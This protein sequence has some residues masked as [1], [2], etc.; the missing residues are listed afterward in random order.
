MYR[1]IPIPGGDF[2]LNLLKSGLIYNQYEDS[3]LGYGEEY[4]YAV[5]Y[6]LGDEEYFST[7]SLNFINNINSES[8]RLVTATTDEIVYGCT[9]P[10]ACS[11]NPDANYLS[12]SCWWSTF[13]CACDAN[14]DGII[15]DSDD[16]DAIVDDCGVCDKD[17]ENDDADDLGCGC[18]APPPDECNNCGGSCIADDEGFITCSYSDSIQ[19]DCNGVCIPETCNDISEPGCAELDECDICN[20]DGTSCLSLYDGLI[21]EVFSIQNI[22]SNPFNPYANIVYGVPE[23]SQVTVTV[24]DIQGRQITVLQNELQSPGYHAIQWDAAQ[25][26]SGV[27]FIEML[28]GDFRQ[29]KRVLHMK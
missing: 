7:D 21:P 18:F 24:Y 6:L 10:S 2:I 29:I 4:T 19:A 15:S 5:S 27:Y 16:R 3:N 20:G 17:P 9:F 23:L 25:Y 11:Y 12:D 8:A 1:Q 14:A 22:Y 26:S 13:G 28:S